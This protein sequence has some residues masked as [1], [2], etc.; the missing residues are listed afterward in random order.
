M[1]TVVGVNAF[2][3]SAPSPLTGDTGDGGFLAVDAKA[4]TDQIAALER[5]RAARDQGAVD[6][7]LAA[8]AACARVGGRLNCTIMTLYDH[9]V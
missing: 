9:S 6:A 5:W 1:Q 7:A 8:L 3:E 2:A 4:E